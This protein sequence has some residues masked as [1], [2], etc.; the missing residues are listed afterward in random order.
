MYAIR[1]YYGCSRRDPSRFDEDWA[2][3][4]SNVLKEQ[5]RLIKF[6]AYQIQIIITIEISQDP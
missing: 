6:T 3:L 1:S 2:V 5:D 4:G